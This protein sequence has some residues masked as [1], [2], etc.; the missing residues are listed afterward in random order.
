MGCFLELK[1]LQ[2]D[3]YYDGILFLRYTLFYP[4]GE[5]FSFAEEMT[6]GY[7]AYLEGAFFDKQK[8]LYDE[9]PNRRKRFYHSVVQITQKCKVYEGDK[10]VS[11]YLDVSENEHRYAFGFTWQKGTSI[12]MTLRDF[13]IKHRS[14]MAKNLFYYDG[15][16]VSVFSKKGEFVEKINVGRENSFSL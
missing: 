9:N 16:S 11:I 10:L 7:A 14:I 12:M 6:K 8:A 1:K 4:D 13:G 3:L 2:K 5:E 15:E